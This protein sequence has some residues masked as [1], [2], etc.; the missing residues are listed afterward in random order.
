MAGV[1][2]CSGA[3]GGD[4][5]QTLAPAPGDDLTVTTSAD[6]GITTAVGDAII[7][8]GNPAGPAIISFDDGGSAN[9]ITGAGYGIYTVNYGPGSISITTTGAVTGTAY[10]GIYA[11][12]SP[13]G[14]SLTITTGPGAVTGGYYGIYT[15]NHGNAG[16]TITAGGNVTGQTYHGIHG[17]NS[18][19][20]VTASMVIN[21]TAGTVTTGAT[22]AIHAINLG[23]SLTINALGTTTGTAGDGILAYNSSSATSL[24][25]STG[26]GVVTGG[27]DGVIAV[28]HGTAGLTITAG[29]NVEGQTGHGIHGYN[30]ANDMTASMAIN[31]TAGT[32]TKGATDAIYAINLGGSLTINALGTTTGTAGDAIHARNVGTDLTITANIATGSDDGISANSYGTGAVSVTTTGT[33]TGNTDEGIDVENSSSGTSLTIVAGGDVNSFQS[34]IQAQNDGTGGLSITVNGNVTSQTVDGIY[35][36]N[37]ANDVTTSMLIDQAA[38]T[39][40]TGAVNGINANNLGGSLTINALGS[41]NGT[42][43]DGI[44]ALNNVAGT[45]TSTIT[46]NNASGA[47]N[48]IFASNNP[49]GIQS[50]TVTG[51]VTGGTGNGIAT[52]TTAGGT[53]NITLN[54][55]ASVSSTAGLGIS[56]DAGGSTTT[57][58]TGAAVSGAISLSNGSDNL[59]FAGSDFSGVTLFNGGDDTDILSFIGSSGS[60]AGAT[61]TNWE[62]VVI[63]TGTTAFSDSVL[64]AGTVTVQNGG[65]LDNTDGLTLTG[66]LSNASIVTMQDGDATDTTTVSGDYSGGGVLNINTVFGDETSASD[67]LIINGN[68]SGATTINISNLGG[69]GAA[70]SGNGI[71]VVQVDGTSG[72]TFSLP[73]PINVNGYE[74]TLVKVGNNWYLQAVAVDVDVAMDK[75]LIST[76]PFLTGGTV[77]YELTISNAGPADATDIEVSDTLTNMSFL[78]L[79]GG[80]CSPASFPCTIPTLANGASETLTLIAS[81]TNTGTFDNTATA[82]PSEIDLDTSNNTDADGNSGIVVE[83]IP[84][85]NQWAQW[86]LAAMLAGIGLLGFRVPHRKSE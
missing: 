24:T 48:G 82:T 23:G 19:N 65:T 59:T 27:V 86:L 25:I 80:T 37:S 75:Q 30:S 41:S 66:A 72:G 49:T 60:L 13:T 12:N 21:Q 8:A 53:T 16:L 58:N 28:N 56:N 73:A 3:A 2:Y 6:F 20:D 84:T 18:A 51:T 83:Q 22:A 34:A 42:A 78:S 79:T 11:Y 40:T 45:T 5:T 68:S 69:T 32:V 52:Y 1:Y 70:T 9:E 31:Q 29:G 46:A 74:Y 36:Y 10:D 71:L 61:V 77:T 26:L 81:I 57:V 63:D 76:G 35:A 38:G 50:I 14:T 33:V 47:V 43:G 44:H 39:I 17:Y 55:G 4:L 7:L 15:A 54:S 64:S 67:V 85:M 62:Q